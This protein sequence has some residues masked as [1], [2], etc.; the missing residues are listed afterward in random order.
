MIQT[1]TKTYNNL[2]DTLQHFISA[3]DEK[4][5]LIDI[6]EIEELHGRVTEC[7]SIYK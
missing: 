5:D 6:I 1:V 3:Y 2:S 7:K 4:G